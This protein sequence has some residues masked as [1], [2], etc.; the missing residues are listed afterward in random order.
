M[1]SYLLLQVENLNRFLSSCN[2]VQEL[3]DHLI[4]NWDD[5]DRSRKNR[6]LN[7]LSAT[8]TAAA[9][10]ITESVENRLKMWTALQD[11][12]KVEKKLVNNT[13]LPHEVRDVMNV[14]N[15]TNAPLER[16]RLVSFLA[17]RY[18]FAF[19]ALFNPQTPRSSGDDDGAGEQSDDEDEI[20]L[21]LDHPPDI[22]WQP[23]LSRYVELKL[24]DADRCS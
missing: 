16:R 24:S 18:T 6:L 12:R 19:L 4:Q 21:K 2:E 20:R 15:Y 14:Y 3:D 8:M 23:P 11:S 22:T 5:A 13:S 7:I 17:I 9:S 1:Y 10:T